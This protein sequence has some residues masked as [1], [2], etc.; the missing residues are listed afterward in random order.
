[1]PFFKKCTVFIKWNQICDSSVNIYC[2]KYIC[3][4][5]LTTH[6]LLSFAA[7]ECAM[8]QILRGSNSVEAWVLSLHDSYEPWT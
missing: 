7:G 5:I 6:K 2:A 4:F 3:F 8:R 1:M